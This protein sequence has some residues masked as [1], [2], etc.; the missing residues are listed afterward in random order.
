MPHV[1]PWWLGYLLACPIRKLWQDPSKLLAPYIREGMTVFEP[2]PGMGFFTLEAARRVGPSGRV[3]VSDIQPQMLARL[4]RR[5]AKAGLL[6]RLEIRTAGADSMG[7]DGLDGR[8]DF[9]FAIAVVHELPSAAAFFAE[10]AAVLKPGG[11]LLVSEPGGHV[12]PAD[13]QAQ[14]EAAAQ[15]GF[16]LVERPSISRNHS[17]LFRR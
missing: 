1:C 10:A 2:G 5:A 3:I 16:T 6:E 11:A 7:L 15:A 12:K 14:I 13:F 9:A 8:A 4:R 17:A